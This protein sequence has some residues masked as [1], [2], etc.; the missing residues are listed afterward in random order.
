MNSTSQLV[1]GIF[2]DL[3]SAP[4]CYEG[5]AALMNKQWGK[6]IS[7]YIVGIPLALIGLSIVGIIPVSSSWVTP[8]V[9][10]LATDGRW[11]LV[12]LLFVL[13]WIGGPRFIERIRTAWNAKPQQRN[14]D[15]RELA[16][17]QKQ[18]PPPSPE[19]VEAI[20]AFANV[21]DSRPV[22]DASTK[23]EPEKPIPANAQ[24]KPKPR[25]ARSAADERTLAM[26]REI[27]QESARHKA[28]LLAFNNF[29]TTRPMTDLEEEKWIKLDV[30][31][32]T[33]N[34]ELTLKFP[35]DT[36]DRDE[37]AL[38]L[39]LYGYRQIYGR[40]K[41]EARRLEHG[42]QS[43]GIRKR[44]PPQ[45]ATAMMSEMILG[46]ARDDR[47]DIDVLAKSGTLEGRISEKFALAAGGFYAITDKG[48]AE[49]EK[50]FDDLVRRA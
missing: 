31:F 48:L 39:L 47:I 1:L 36:Y 42:L 15:I 41:V 38:L 34:Q 46:H 43:S 6:A 32:R 5:C 12:V 22:G 33:N 45:T 24:E 49:I 35:P 20:R 29:K 26:A 23:L 44:L 14:Y 25:K 11:W 18:M 19:K 30:L 8:I 2:V 21:L 37:D 27:D 16:M 17:P 50:V 4:F 10:P 13:L 40:E 28:A 7:A 3:I 9:E